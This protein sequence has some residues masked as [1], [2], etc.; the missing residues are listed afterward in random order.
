MKN[1]LIK[2]RQKTNYGSSLNIMHFDQMIGFKSLHKSTI[3]SKIL[4]VYF[5]RTKIKQLLQIIN[6]QVNAPETSTEYYLHDMI[7]IQFVNTL[8]TI[9][10]LIPIYRIT[11][12]LKLI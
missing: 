8:R 12:I 10:G 9:I 2:D 3:L 11:K 1:E 4:M 5:T 7:L 6:H